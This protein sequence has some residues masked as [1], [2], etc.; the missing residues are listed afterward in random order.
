MSIDDAVDAALAGLDAGELI[1]IPSLPDAAHWD[2][3]E[4]ARLALV[5]NMSRREPAERYQR[6]RPAL[7]RSTPMTGRTV[8]SRSRSANARRSTSSPSAL[9]ERGHDHPL[10][11][12]QV[13]LRDPLGLDVHAV[14]EA[15]L[16]VEAGEV[17][18]EALQVLLRLARGVAQGEERRVRGDDAVGVRLRRRVR[19]RGAAGAVAEAVVDQRPVLVGRPAVGVGADPVDAVDAVA[20]LGTVRRREAPVAVAGLAQAVE[21]LRLDRQRVVDAPARAA[22]TSPRA[23]TGRASAPRT[24]S[25]STRGRRACR[26]TAGPPRRRRRRSSCGSR[27]RPAWSRS[28][29]SR[30]CPGR[31]GSG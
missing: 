28:R 25:R 27:R 12:R 23:R 15:P 1:T 11:E 26:R 24:C 3:Y 6:Q 7:N 17:A 31:C 4:A 18:R 13:G 19:L 9:P 8:R 29:T 10:V 21:D 2:A 14:A 20:A 22:P 5:P 30:T 16:R